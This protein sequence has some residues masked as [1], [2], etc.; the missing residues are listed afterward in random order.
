[1]FF[2]L[3]L[4]LTTIIQ[5]SNYNRIYINIGFHM[6]YNV[7]MIKNAKF[8]TFPSAVLIRM[9]FHKQCILGR[10]NVSKNLCKNV[11][12]GW[13]LVSGHFSKGLLGLLS[14]CL[15]LLLLCHK[16]ILKPVHLLLQFKHRLLGKLG[17]G[18]SLLQLGSQGLDLLL[19][20]LLPLVGLLLGHLQGLQVVRHNPQLLLQLEDLGLTDISALLGLLEVGLTGSQLLG[21]LIVGCVGG[22]G[23]LSC[24]LQVLLQSNDPLLVFVSLLWKT[25]LARSES[26]AAVP[27]LS[28]LATAATIFSSVFSRS[29]SSPE[30]LLVSAFISSSVAASCFSFSSNCRVAM[31]RRSEVTSSSVSSCLDLITS[32]STSSSPFWARILAAFIFSSLTSAWSQALSFSTFIACIFFL[33]ASI[34][35]LKE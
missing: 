12:F 11:V 33:I 6:T 21:D 32:S 10:T 29:S 2:I 24:L 16:L 31:D 28:S 34:L 8:N 13:I 3:T 18:L 35:K 27:A 9:T 20:G 17:A 14:D 25:F 7:I 1:M 4:Y 19:V 22:L 23:L 5:Y 26:S 30:T 15:V